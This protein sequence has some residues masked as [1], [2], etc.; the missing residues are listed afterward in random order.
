[1]N[2]DVDNFAQSRDGIAKIKSAPFWKELSERTQP[3][4]PD[5]DKT[6]ESKQK[7]IID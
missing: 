5:A 7:K 1:M 6:Y 2:F 3:T 4:Y